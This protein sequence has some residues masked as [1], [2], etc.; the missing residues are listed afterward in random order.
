VKNS[1]G[2]TT[3]LS[4]DRDPL[5]RGQPQLPLS[6]CDLN[7]VGGGRATM[8]GGHEGRLGR[9]RERERNKYT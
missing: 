1:N 7:I 5:R 2:L 4:S 6:S 9:E 3:D 8:N